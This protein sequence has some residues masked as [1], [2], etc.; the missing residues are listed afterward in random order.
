[1]GSSAENDAMR[2]VEQCPVRFAE[3][4]P[5]SVEVAARGVK[6]KAPYKAMA[7]RAA[8]I[9]RTEELARNAYAA[10]QRGDLAA[11]IVLARAVVECTALMARLVHVVFERS[12][13][14]EEELDYTLNK[15][16]LGWKSPSDMPEAFNILTPID[17]LNRQAPGVRRAYDLMSEFAHP[18]WSGVSSLFSRTDREKYVTH[19][20]R[21]ETKQEALRAKA[22]SALAACLAIFEFDYN[23]F[24]D[25]M[26]VW[27][28]ELERLWPAGAPD[29]WP[30]WEVSQR[31]TVSW[32]MS[33]PRSN[34]RS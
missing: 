10:L 31:R 16:L 34:S 6:A 30:S 23:K 7:I 25:V 28:A 12:K 14:T 20:G 32:Q 21:F 17:H 26:P 29:H 11:A 8:L 1:M 13:A 33:M 4:L 18:N 22:V 27:L 5:Q 24:A 3:S 9:W 19:F 15:M 2:E